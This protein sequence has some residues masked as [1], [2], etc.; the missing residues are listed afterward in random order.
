MNSITL[1]MQQFDSGSQQ[2]Y[3]HSERKER[4]LNSNVKVFF[5]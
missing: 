1:N 4:N 2:P 5:V 3:F